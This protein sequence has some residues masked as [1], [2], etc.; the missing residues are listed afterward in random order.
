MSYYKMMKQIN[1]KIEAGKVPKRT[2]FSGSGLLARSSMPT[3]PM[4]AISDDIS[5]ELASYISAIRKQKEELL[6]G[7]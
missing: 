5:S 7:K 2:A 3:G 4:S 6:N 1:E